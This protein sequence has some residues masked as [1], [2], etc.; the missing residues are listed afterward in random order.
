L[1]LVLPADRDR[2]SLPLATTVSQ[3]IISENQHPGEKCEQT[4]EHSANRTLKNKNK[5]QLK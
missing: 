4:W 5:Q 1:S 2:V 3:A